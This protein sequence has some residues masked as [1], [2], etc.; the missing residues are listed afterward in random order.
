MP[1]AFPLQD[2]QQLAE[3]PGGHAGSQAACPVR[4]SASQNVRLSLPGHTPPLNLIDKMGWNLTGS[5]E[6]QRVSVCENV[7]VTV[8]PCLGAPCGGRAARQESVS[9]DVRWADSVLAVPKLAPWECISASSFARKELLV[10]PAY[11]PP[12]LSHRSPPPTPL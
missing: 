8:E 7:L 11:T 10:L 3:V 5:P 12:S 9:V 2:R 6:G 1:D 4:G